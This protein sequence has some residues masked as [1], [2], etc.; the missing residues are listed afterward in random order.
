MLGYRLLNGESWVRVL[1]VV[2]RAAAGC[3]YTIYRYGV[4]EDASVDDPTGLYR[5][6][7]LV[8]LPVRPLKHRGCV[9]EVLR[10]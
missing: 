9:R 10:T 6:I 3:L 4:L 8:H 1:V 7:R 5:L 2:G